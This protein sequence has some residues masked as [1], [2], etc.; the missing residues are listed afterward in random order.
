MQK[1]EKSDNLI[2]NLN[3][4][5]VESNDKIMGLEGQ[6]AKSKYLMYV[7]ELENAKLDVSWLICIYVFYELM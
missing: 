3:Q 7:K 2:D 1:L 5:L 6:C 4:K